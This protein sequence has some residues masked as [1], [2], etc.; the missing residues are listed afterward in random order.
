M[1]TKQAT[2]ADTERECSR[3]KKHYA[4][5]LDGD[6]SRKCPHCGLATPVISQ[7]KYESLE[8]HDYAGRKDGK[9]WMLA[10]TEAG[11][12]LFP[13]VLVVPHLDGERV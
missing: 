1:A 12:T 9:V 13:D 7:E 8:R 6:L 10:P 5:P 3:C 4:L 2:Q 11:T